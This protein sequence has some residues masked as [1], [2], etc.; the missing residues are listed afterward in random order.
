MYSVL[1]VD[2]ELA[3]REGLTALLDWESS[4]FQIIDTAA[5]AIEAKY[6]YELYSPDLMIVDIRM[7]GRDGL[8]LIKELRENDPEMHIIILSGYADFDYAK[9]ALAF[10]IDNYLLK[11][12]DELEL[13]LYLAKLS[14]ELDARSS[15]RK[16]HAAVKVWSRE[17]L[18]QSLLMENSPQMLPS[19]EA[20]IHEAG[21]LWD[22]YQVVLIRL[23]LQDNADNGPSTAVKPDL[24]QALMNRRGDCLLAGLLFGGSPAALLSEG[25]C[26]QINGTEYTASRNCPWA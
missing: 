24:Q 16:N 26:T 17:M 4:G 3:I 12:V 21:L 8:E 10:G 1:I 18:V 19:M 23:L 25:A 22:S 5:N 13:Q 11:P 6:K 20:S 9:R 7:P 2:D 15:H 14:A